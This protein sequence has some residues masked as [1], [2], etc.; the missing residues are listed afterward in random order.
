MQI[1]IFFPRKRR[2]AAHR[3]SSTIEMNAA[4]GNLFLTG[5]S[6]TDAAPNCCSKYGKTIHF[7]IFNGTWDFQ[8]IHFS[9]TYQLGEHFVVFCCSTM[10][11]S[12]IFLSSL[13]P[14]VNCNPARVVGCNG[15]V[16][17]FATPTAPWKQQNLIS[18]LVRLVKAAFPSGF[19]NVPSKKL[20]IRKHLRMYYSTGCVKKFRLGNLSQDRTKSFVK[21]I[22]NCNITPYG[23]FGAMISPIVWCVDDGYLLSALWSVF[24]LC[25]M[26]VSRIATTFYSEC[27][28][29]TQEKSGNPSLALDLILAFAMES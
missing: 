16:V 10:Q 1:S 17:Y 11:Q 8:T 20:Y 4:D 15:W 28:S 26:R 12:L 22:S 14:F 2:R 27:S 19:L 13:P 6:K 5:L 29:I 23:V 24:S 7:Y 21:C 3:K 18:T 9:S 25:S